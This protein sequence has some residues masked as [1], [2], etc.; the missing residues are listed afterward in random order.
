[1]TM[2]DQWARKVALAAAFVTA[3]AGLASLGA[4][5]VRTSA[6]TPFAVGIPTVVDPV[7]GAGEPRIQVDNAGNPW[8]SGPGG[9]STQTSWF[10]H[11]MD[12]GLTYNLLGPS[13]GHWVCASTGGGDSWLQYD[14]VNGDLYVQDQQALADLAMGKT[15]GTGASL[16]SACFANPAVTADRG[17]EAIVH[18][19]GAVRAPQFVADGN[20]PLIYLS[21]LCQG[22][23]GGGTNFA[24]GLAY[25]WSDDGVTWHAADAGVPAD[26]LVTDQFYEASAINSFQ[27]HG[28]MVADQETGYV[29]TGISCNSGGC[30]N[31]SGKVEFGVAI[32]RPGTNSA[33][34]GQF[35]NETYQT[36]SDKYNGQ[37]WPEN[38]S[39][40]PV[41][42]MDSAG[43]LYE[44]WAITNTSTSGTPPAASG[45]VYY[46][47]SKDKPNHQVWSAPIRID[48]GPDSA[49][50]TMPW[51]A[52]G[53]P[54]KVAFVW[55][56]TPNRAYPSEKDPNKKWWPNMAIS[57]NGD[58]PSPTLQQTRVGIGPS[59]YSDI[60]LMGTTCG[61]T[62]PPGNRN[63]ADFIS[64]DIT[65]D[66]AAQAVW[67]SDA[68]R[69]GGPAA[70]VPGVPLT[71]TARQVSG[72]RL[73]GSGD[74]SDSRFST[75]PSDVGVTDPLGDALY[76]VVT[77]GNVKQLDLNRSWVRLEGNNLHV[78]MG[79]A[80]LTS[81]TSPNTLQPNVWWLTTWQ[82][83]ST[84][85]YAK[86]ESDS[87]GAITYTAGTPQSY[88][89]P[90]LTY[91]AVPT[92]VDYRTGTAVTGR[93]STGEFDIVVPTSVVGS[94]KAG[95]VLES[96]AAYTVLDTGANAFVTAGP[97][98]V[99]T[100]VDKTAAYNS[101]LG[102][103]AAPGASPTPTA[104]GGG[105]SPAPSASPP[106]P[107]TATSS[108]A[109]GAGWLFLAGF[110]LALIAA[111][112]VPRRSRGLR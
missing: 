112:G 52:A 11:S 9:S 87:G 35:G 4:P 79:V 107:A 58:T 100:I 65:R 64:I 61:A 21:W 51:I 66:G 13:G 16:N 49:T 41:L 111:L 17:F 48:Q 42:A 8:I 63:M 32:G 81:L 27:W 22:C 43:T 1:M 59:H 80:G 31:N 101:L 94:P 109:S 18:P 74:V 60:C 36:A 69:M 106:L 23:G 102:A 56:G 14:Q 44:M 55:L 96:V 15:T 26:T 7:R 86:A 40:F 47:Y 62:S 97:G 46:A 68:N 85:Y 78:H 108:P 45:H 37:P 76:P 110:G 39:L 67:A 34:V 3:L 90:G 19:T 89:R 24:K 70:L 95:D 2:R 53:D 71:V 77:G 98:N 75:T 28:N 57:T 73:I 99:P 72:P 82:F 6:Q 29:F 50:A 91:Y 84:I 88:D 83:G 25:A 12:G 30:P 5:P 103:A 33:N 38:G 92:L 105:A 20:K 93:N 10:W 104:G 54:G